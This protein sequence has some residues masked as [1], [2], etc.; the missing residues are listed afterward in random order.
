MLAV[1]NIVY[2]KY[3]CRCLWKNTPPENDKCGKTSFPRADQGLESGFRL[4]IAG[5]RLY[6]HYSYIN[7]D[8]NNDENNNTDN[9]ASHTD[10]TCHRSA[11]EESPE[12]PRHKSLI[13]VLASADHIIKGV[14]CTQTPVSLRERQGNNNDERNQFGIYVCTI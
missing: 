8:N 9:N 13:R 2:D 5:Q 1:R 4:W 14:F 10:S 12:H 6:D 3:S 11:P 7:H